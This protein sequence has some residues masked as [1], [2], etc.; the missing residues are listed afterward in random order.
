MITFLLGFFGYDDPKINSMVLCKNILYLPYLYGYNLYLLRKIYRPCPSGIYVFTG[1]QGSGKTL[2]LVYTAY[3]LCKNAN[4]QIFYSNMNLKGFQNFH[5]FDELLGLKKALCICDELGIVANSKKSK[6]INEE[7][8]K[9]TAQNRK[10][11]RLI[12]TT[13]QQYYQ[14]NKDI[15]TQAKYIIE[16]SKFGCIVINRFYIPCVDEDG[17]IR[18]SKPRKIR[19]FF[20]TKKL[21]S[22]YD[23]TEVIL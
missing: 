19:I 6:D 14:C 17:N 13:A 11:E 9:I 12:L 20:A 16:C 4:Y 15:R 22:L 10:N 5:K 21:Y 7:L 3:D 23:T 1:K 8:L 2:S 18:N